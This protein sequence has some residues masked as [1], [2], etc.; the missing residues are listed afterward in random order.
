MVRLAHLTTASN[1]LAEELVQDA[2]V[3]LFRNWD[4]VRDPSAW[5][6][7][8]VMSRCTSWVRRQHLERRVAA[9][10]DVPEPAIPDETGVAV[11]EALLAL[12]VRQ[13]AAVVLRYLEDAS[14]RDIAD[15]LGC[16]RGT[17]KSLLSRAMS[18][19]QKDLSP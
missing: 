12:S 11:R 2:F 8:A 9:R 16:R 14:E 5:L 10:H 17:V 15:A 13:R 3:D 19:L 1:A 18:K 4:T 7:R 6:R